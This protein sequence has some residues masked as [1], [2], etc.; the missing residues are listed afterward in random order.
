MSDDL[1]LVRGSGNPFRDVGLPDPDT[2]I[3]KADLGAAI[4]RVL[5]TRELSGAEAARGA[6]VPEADISRIRNADLG[7]FTIDRLVRI[8]NRLDQT[9]EIHVTVKAGD[10]APAPA[11]GE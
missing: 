11:A 10:G 5:R 6:G 9:V 4:M 8:L 7:R 2:K 1:D 3:I